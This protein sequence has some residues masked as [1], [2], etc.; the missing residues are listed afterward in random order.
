[1]DVEI[2]KRVQHNQE[3]EIKHPL[4]GMFYFV[5]ETTRCKMTATMKAE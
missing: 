2:E 1:M 5:Q 4:S 3:H